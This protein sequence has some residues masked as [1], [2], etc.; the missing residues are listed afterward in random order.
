MDKERFAHFV[1]NLDTP[2]KCVFAS[3]AIHQGCVLRTLH[4]C[5]MSSEQIVMMK[6]TRIM[7]I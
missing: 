4:P 5:T 3:M 1:E 7:M 6:T 2:L